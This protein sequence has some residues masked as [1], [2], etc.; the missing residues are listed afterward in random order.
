[1]LPRAARRLPVGESRFVDPTWGG[2]RVLAMVRG[3][4]VRLVADG[5]DVG[6]RFPL[7]VASLAEAGLTSALLDGEIVLPDAARRGL[8]GAPRRPS[9]TL[10]PATLVASDVL[11]LD[12]RPQ[13]GEPLHRRRDRLERLGLASPAIVALQPA[14]GAEAVLATAALHGLVGVVAKR[15]DSPYLPGV[16]SRL[17]TLV[18]ATDLG[19]DPDLPADTEEEDGWGRTAGQPDDGAGG[20]LSGTATASGR[21]ARVD[22]AL[23][24]TLPL[25]EDG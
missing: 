2:L 19:L 7:I 10:Q 24:R 14:M 20:G 18:R 12:G 5:Y 16:R 17:W 8:A 25:G 11:W 3:P 9:P 15:A 4:E 6:E 1:M 13:L 21:P 22:I 23:L